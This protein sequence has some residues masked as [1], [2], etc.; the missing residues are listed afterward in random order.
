MISIPSC[1]HRAC[2]SHKVQDLKKRESKAY[3]ILYACSLTRALH[4]DLARSMEPAKFL[5]S[6]K[7]MLAGGG[8]L[9]T[10]YSE[11]GS[12]LESSSEERSTAER[13]PCPSP[14]CLEV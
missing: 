8:R 6:L 12:S 1:G 14:V 7:G 11:N 10:I 4:L 13:L 2:R 3:V 5:L 9:S